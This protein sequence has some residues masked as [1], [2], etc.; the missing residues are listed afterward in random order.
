[1]NIIEVDESRG[2]ISKCALP[3]NRLLLL[4]RLVY[5]VSQFL[6]SHGIRYFM[7]G[8]TLLG[9]VRHQKQI[10]WAHSIPKAC[11]NTYNFGCIQPVQAS[12]INS[13]TY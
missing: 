9:A 7:D 10:P 13:S 11:P 6:D 5:D 1:M 12:P 8:G 4:Y 2:I 3:K